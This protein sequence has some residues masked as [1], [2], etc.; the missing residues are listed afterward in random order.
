MVTSIVGISKEIHKYM[1]K[2]PSTGSIVE[3][4]TTLTIFNHAALLTNVKDV[5]LDKVNPN[6]LMNGAAMKFFNTIIPEP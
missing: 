5:Y 4:T 2:K 3:A 1:N 6:T